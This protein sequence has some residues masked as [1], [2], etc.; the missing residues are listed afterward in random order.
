MSSFNFDEK[1]LKKVKENFQ[2]HCPGEG[3]AL[4]V[5][6]D[7]TPITRKDSGEIFFLK[8]GEEIKL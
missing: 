3:R 8:K 5:T 6:K 7:G 2:K 1:D 4:I